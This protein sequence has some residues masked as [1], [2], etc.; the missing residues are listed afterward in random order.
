VP[1]ATLLGDLPPLKPL[2]KRVP[3][4][5]SVLLVGALTCRAKAMACETRG[6]G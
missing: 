6:G 2:L 3:Q 1:S 5:W 4:L